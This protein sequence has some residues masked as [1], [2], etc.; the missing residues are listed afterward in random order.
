MYGGFGFTM[1]LMFLKSRSL[2]FPFHPGGYVLTTGG[3]FGREWFATFVSWAL[4]LVILRMGGIKAYRAA[5]P[6]FLGVLL[7]DYT[8]GCLWSLIGLI[9]DTPTYGVWH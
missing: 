3:G 7:G 4:K 8:M 1:L 2:W 6:F 5:A 9:W